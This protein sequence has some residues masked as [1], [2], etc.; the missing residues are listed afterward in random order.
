MIRTRCC[1]GRSK[2]YWTTPRAF[3]KAFRRALK[4]IQN[5]HRGTHQHSLGWLM[6]RLSKAI[7]KDPFMKKGQLY[8]L[9]DSLIAKTP[10]PR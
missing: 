4:Y 6:T 2:R 5:H 7:T 3:R 9:I 1:S 10:E 8:R